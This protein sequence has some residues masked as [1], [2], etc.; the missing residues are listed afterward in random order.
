[1]AGRIRKGAFVKAFKDS[2]VNWHGYLAAVVSVA[3]ATW[4]KVLAQ[5]D[6]I[7]ANVPILYML[8]IVVTAFFFGFGPA[9]LCCLLSAVAFDYFFI[10]P[11]YTVG[12]TRMSDAPILGIF[13]VVGI[14]ISYLESTLR[15]RTEEAIGEATA[16]RGAETA[17][18]EANE[19]LE[20]RVAERTHEL[21]RSEH[22]WS[23]TLASIGD[24]VIA[25]DASGR[26]TFMNV[27]AES[28]TGWSLSEAVSRP[29]AD[30]F[31]IIDE[32]TRQKASDPVE[33]VLERG[34]VAVLDVHSLLVRRD[35]TETPIDDSGAPIRDQDGGVV[36]VV[37]VFRDITERRKAEQIKDDF[38]GMVSHELRTPLTVVIG[39]IRTAMTPGMP[40][41]DIQAL[42]A[43]AASGSD[44]LE[45]I[46]GNLLELSRFE[47]NRLQLAHGA[48]DISGLIR[49][50]TD[51][52]RN[53]ARSHRFVVDIPPDMPRVPADPFR[54]DRILHNLLNNAVKYSPPETEVRVSV[55]REQ[56]G[57]V[58]TV[59]DQGMGIS[60]EDKAKLF[61]PFQ[62]L[63][64][65]RRA[66]QG[67][68]LGLI[69]CLR[70]VEAHGGRIWVDSEPGKGSSFS[71]TL[72]LVSPAE[73]R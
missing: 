38:I 1:L 31:N 30:V 51:R 53:Q 70:L 58:V 12:P 71:F 33:A 34:A 10:P 47:A 35:E 7:A 48:M 62:R 19:N 21:S 52:E 29:I 61:A 44:E 5:P 32:N 9:I 41:E 18:R 11:L 3:L 49:Q 69:V 65:T 42:L 64:S 27:V 45:M 17:L 60:H 4:L 16:R 13:L 23:T 67:V 14:T 46:L 56:D 54:I 68:G 57:V 28:L 24:G 55:R 15:S 66:I 39:S 8:S 72:P 36:G 25:T 40:A 2:L 22:R 50:V 37:V 6:I 63:E 59:S 20:R 43:D 73:H 26:I